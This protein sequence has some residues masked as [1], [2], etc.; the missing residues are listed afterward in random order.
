MVAKNY[1]EDEFRSNTLFTDESVFESEFMPDGI[2]HRDNELIFLSRLF[3]PLL[4]NPFTLSKKILI[5]GG[6]GFIGHHVIEHILKNTDWH[7]YIIDKL[8]YASMGNDRLRDIN[9]M[10]ESRVNRFTNDLMNP[11]SEGIKKELKGDIDIILHMAAETHVDNSIS[12]PV[13][14]VMNNIK[15]TLEL[16][17]YARTLPNLE[18]FIY[19]STDEVYGTAPNKINYKEGDRH[20][21]GNPYS[22]SKSG[23]E[24]LVRAYSNTYNIPSIITNTMNVLGERQHPEKFL[25]LIIKSILN[26]NTLKIHSDSSKTK[27]GSRYYIHAR[28]VAD[29]IIYI[30]NNVD[31]VLDNIDASKGVFNIV[32]ELEIDNLEL[33]KI[34]ARHLNKELKYEM[35]DFHSSRPGH[36]LR[37]ALNGSKMKNLGWVPPI[38]IVNSIKKIVDWTLKPNNKR[39]LDG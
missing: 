9:I 34:V 16:L 24:S 35:I 14:F 19:F 37:Y 18:K 30:I 6:N 2:K 29:G 11:I 15:S 33:A 27:A 21:P 22:A 23:S 31:E 32:G 28:N 4:T 12:E 36:D 17:E 1:L 20:N 25:P 10:D 7:I 39:W 8:S 38:D 5:T 13:N 26:S 3:L